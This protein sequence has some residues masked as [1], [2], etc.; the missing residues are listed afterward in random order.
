[1]NALIAVATEAPIMIKIIFW[2]LI[3]LWALGAFFAGD[4]PRWVQGSKGLLIVL[5]AIL[6]YYT[7]G[8]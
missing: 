3:I 2:I 5:F 7:F 8:F 1:M 4:N 6:G